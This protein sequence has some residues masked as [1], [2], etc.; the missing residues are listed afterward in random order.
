MLKTVIQHT[1]RQFARAIV[2]RNLVPPVTSV[3]AARAYHARI[4]AALRPHPNPPPLAGE[5]ME[6]GFAPLM[7]CYLTDTTDLKEAAPGF[8]E[9]GFPPVQLYPPPATHNSA[10]GVHDYHRPP[11]VPE[12]R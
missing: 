8:Q 2:M 6:G 10:P 9:G 5:G 3:P 4:I 12:P 1:A 7:T 11:P